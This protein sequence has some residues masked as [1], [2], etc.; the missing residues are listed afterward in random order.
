MEPHIR[1]ARADEAQHLSELALRSKAHWGYS[2]QFMEACRAELTYSPQVCGS[3]TVIVAE[4]A[5][6]LG[7]YRLVRDVPVSRLE[8]LFVEPDEQGFGVGKALLKHALSAAEG[9]GAEVVELEA[10]PNAEPFYTRCGAVRVGEV[11]SGSIR[12]RKL[13]LMRFDLTGT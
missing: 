12:G 6:V 9:L 10:D 13:P 4:R 11:P 1:P 8:A 5:A 3:G 7:F 2:R